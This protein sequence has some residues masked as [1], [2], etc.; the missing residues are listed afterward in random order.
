MNIYFNRNIRTWLALFAAMALGACASPTPQ[1]RVPLAVPSQVS[2]IYSGVS[3]QLNLI[4]EPNTPSHCSD[5]ECSINHAFN[6][7]VMRLG[8]RLAQ[9]AFETYPHTKER[10]GQFEFVIAEKSEPGSI[11][12]AAGTVAIF[13]GVQKLNLDEEALAFLIAREMGHIIGGHHDENSSTSIWISVLTQLLMPVTGLFNGISA[14]MGTSAMSTATSYISS[15]LV[16]ANYRDK[17]I[18]EA[19]AIASSLLNHQGLE[20]SRVA[21]A[22]I[23]NS[24]VTGEDRWS[25][26]FRVSSLRL[27]QS[28]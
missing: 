23:A 12:N 11:S 3:M 2:N 27:G 22:L 21:H 4:T 17:Q 26:E 16:I 1:K 28:N 6:Q 13:R 10:I 19:D 8:N 5:E 14:I 24:Q 15:S 18:Q 7:Q 25:R 9:S 20:K